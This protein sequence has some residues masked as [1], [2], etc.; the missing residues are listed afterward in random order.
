MG[1]GIIFLFVL[2]SF[3]LFS[4]TTTLEVLESVDFREQVPTT[5]IVGMHSSIEN[6]RGVIKYSTRGYFTFEIF[7]K[8][9]KPSFSKSI[10]LDKRER[11]LA[12]LY[13]ENEI[14]VF[15]VASPK[16]KERKVYCY[17]FN[18]ETKSH[19]KKLLF[20]KVTEKNQSLFNG[21]KKRQTSFA[22]S[23][24]GK[25]MV[26]LTDNINKTTN[27]FTTHVYKANTLELQYKKDYQKNIEKYFDPNDLAINDSA[28]VYV[29]GKQYL[30]GKSDR[31]NQKANYEFLLNRITKEENK[32]TT[33]SLDDEF[34][35][36]LSFAKINEELMV[37]GFYSNRSS[38]RIKGGCSFKLDPTE[39]EILEKSKNEL[40]PE[41]FNGL[42]GYR[43]ALE[44]S[45]RELNNFSIDHVI[46]DKDLNTYVVAEEFYITTTYINNGMN[47]GMMTTTTYHYDDVL[48][49]KFD[50]KGNILWGNSIFKRAT[51]PS[52]NA[53]L[54]KNQLRLILNSGKNLL[55]KEDGR[56]KVSKGWFESS[57]LYDIEFNN[58]NGEPSY[59]KIQ[60]NRGKAYYLP[61]YGTYTSD[62]SFIMINRGSASSYLRRIMLLR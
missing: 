35:S 57:S 4:Q 46:V 40:P 17:I 54:I 50:S 45:N 18:I 61:A 60:D 39:L 42:Y 21:R 10:E 27:S 5:E 36:S 41:V 53:I 25:Y 32:T 59:N 62:G 33:I 24:N 28:V 48:V 14:K 12:S 15:S 34:V 52:Y 51:S 49:L 13:F 58:N 47:G 56:T 2:V 8:N 44:K 31:K 1:K 9:L 16:K 29:I 43:R 6:N 30:K 11:P 20:E 55:K 26:M 23:P 3:Q 19:T 38:N 22:Q 7:D 37:L